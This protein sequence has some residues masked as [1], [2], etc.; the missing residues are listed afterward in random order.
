MCPPKLLGQAKIGPRFIDGIQVFALEILDQ[1]DL[2]ALP[3]R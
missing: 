2:Q 3:V 1:G